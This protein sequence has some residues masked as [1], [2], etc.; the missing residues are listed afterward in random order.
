[1]ASAFFS[2]PPPQSMASYFDEVTGDRLKNFTSIYRLD[3]NGAIKAIRARNSAAERLA[4]LAEFTKRMESIGR[5]TGF[6]GEPKA[7]TDSGSA[8]AKFIIEDG[9]GLKSAS[10]E[11]KVYDKG[12]SLTKEWVKQS[13]NSTGKSGFRLLDVI[14]KIVKSESASDVAKI[15]AKEG[16]K[17]LAEWLKQNSASIAKGALKRVGYNSRARNRILRVIASRMA[18]LKAPMSFLTRI[19]PILF[20]LELLLTPTETVSDFEEQRSMFLLYYSQIQTDQ[21][22]IF[23]SMISDKGSGHAQLAKPLDSYLK[24]SIS[25]ARH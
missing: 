10:V 7:E 22:S 21:S 3:F 20:G 19:Q 23:A 13:L 14:W 8:I 5:E 11:K 6:L 15:L 24:A 18:L 17:E 25:S 2:P 12:V 9:L 16:G 1:M 4:L